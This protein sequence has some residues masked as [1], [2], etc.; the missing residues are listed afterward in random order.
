MPNYSKAKT[1][2]SSKTKKIG[3]IPWA[4]GRSLYLNV[5]QDLKQSEEARLEEIYQEKIAEAESDYY[6]T[7][8]EGSY[9]GNFSD[10]ISRPK[11]VVSNALVDATFSK[12]YKDAFIDKYGLM[13]HTD[14]FLP[15][16][17]TYLGNMPT[18]KNENGK[19]SGL[20][21]RNQN[22]QSDMD[23]GIYRFLM[24][25]ERSSYLKL[26]YKAPAK[27]YCALV[28][29]I[30]YAHK[31]MHQTPYSAWDKNEIGYIVNSDLAKAMMYDC[32]EFTKDEILEQRHLG[33]TPAGGGTLKNPET[34]H[35]LYGPQLKTGIFAEL[36]KLVR[37][38]LAQ[39]W[40]AHPVN[41]TRYMV[42]D[43]N[44]WERMPAALINTQVINSA[45]DLHETVD[46][47]N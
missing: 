12:Q 34:T 46:E 35:M 28:P 14:W 23:K 13:Y 42:L 25:N 7:H 8:E 5:L 30:L 37:V 4:E 9:E 27:Q 3:D 19:L 43:S 17:I 20:K 40:C 32:P 15:Q 24:V 16:I 21:F 33:L 2:F 22:F 11:A 38:M 29:Y 6:N 36:P 18:Y 47:W 31:L 39:I 1:I 44:N 41:R 10:S 26:Q 45:S